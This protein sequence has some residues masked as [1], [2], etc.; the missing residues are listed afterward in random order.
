MDRAALP[1]GRGGYT[2]P[3]SR[4]W[5]LREES[6]VGLGREETWGAGRASS[7]HSPLPVAVP[8]QGVG[9]LRSFPFARPRPL[10]M[11]HRSSTPHSR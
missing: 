1:M 10:A 8:G 2:Q 3:W 7:R 11:V 6:G 9:L 4:N 5:N